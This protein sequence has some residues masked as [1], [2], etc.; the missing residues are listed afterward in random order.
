VTFF[1]RQDKARRQTV[2][3]VL[4]LVVAIGLIVFAIN[5]VVYGLA[6]FVEATPHDLRHWLGQPWWLMLSAAVV[7]T[8]LLGSLM[9]YHGLRGGGYVV[10]EM[11]DGRRIDFD[12]RDTLER[13]LIN[14]VEEMSIASGTPVP[15]LYILDQEAGINAFVAGFKPTEAVMVVT[16]GCLEHLDRD[17]LQGVVGHEYSHI[18]NGDMRLNIRLMAILAGILMIGVAGRTLIGSVFRTRTGYRRRGFMSSSSS[19]ERRGGMVGGQYGI[20]VVALGLALIV[21]GYAGLFC[22]RLIKAA[23]SRQRE[24][25]ADASSVQFTRNSDGIAGALWRIK[26]H[27]AGSFLG[28]GRAEDASHMCFG[29][30]VEMRL[31]GWLATH[32]PLEARVR[33]IDP[34]FRAKMATRKI[35]SGQAASADRRAAAPGTTVSPIGAAGFAGGAGG[36]APADEDGRELL[37]RDKVQVVEQVGS[38]Q[39]E[40]LDYAM[41]LHAAMPAALHT[42]TH[43]PELAVALVYAMLIAHLGPSKVSIGIALVQH[44]AGES[45]AQAARRLH[46]ALRALDARFRL[47]ALELAMP[48]L[49][50]L[51][52]AQRQELLSVCEKLA[53]IDRKI[54]VF[55]VALLTLLRKHLDVHAGRAER[56]R[57]V[58]YGPINK[59]LAVLLSLLAHVGTSSA[60]EVEESFAKAVAGFG[61]DLTLSS[62]EECQ[63]TRMM[64]ILEKLSG[65]SPL[66]K[67]P[68]L[69]ACV[70]CIMHDNKVTIAESE[71]LRAIAESLDCPMPPLAAAA[72]IQ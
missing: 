49:K 33:A 27:E 5:A 11:L 64:T 65:L 51:T 22:G 19:S 2:I 47:P 52:A 41:A 46:E 66:L 15:A 55:E 12:S 57:Y 35:R 21:V 1:Q 43:V 14:V 71:L 44:Q 38:P 7:L 4:W 18:L 23:V 10:A 59:D 50:R 8:I 40:H 58:R 31:T 60:E 61:D 13:R 3:L 26:E 28:H 17:Q 36:V 9:R 29:E 25:L 62:L 34:H 30:G 72:A 67:Q 42:A 20:A 53:R 45:G 37:I 69:E 16:R 63:P 70:E 48:S 6:V 54:T 39:P 24:F 32:P 56:V 68:V